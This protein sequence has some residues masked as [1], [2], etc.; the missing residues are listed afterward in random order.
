MKTTPAIF[1][2]GPTASGKTDL[3]IKLRDHF[4]LDIISVDSAQVFREMNIGTAKPDTDELEK[5]PHKLIDIKDPDESYSAADFRIDAL[6]EMKSIRDQKRI[7]L[8]VGGTNLYFRALQYGLSDLP[9]SDPE[10]RKQ[11]EMRIQSEGLKALHDELKNVDAIA[12]GRIHQND[13]QRTMRALEVYLLTGTPM[14]ALQGQAQADDFCFSVFKIQ[15]SPADRSG[16][17]QRIAIRFR[18]MI[19]NGLIE[20]VKV[21]RQRWPLHADLP[22]MRAVGYRQVWDYLEG[23]RD[24]EE[25]IEKGIIATRQLAK[26]QLTWL[27]QEQAIL[28]VNESDAETLSE[29]VEKIRE[30]L[31]MSFS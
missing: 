24:R 26:R 16:L 12:A 11:L 6:R 14:S 28:R 9:P 2:M 13:Q 30:F 3:A 27:R 15:I 19:D 20:E 22:S 8:L 4:P 5:A 7:P 18:Q 31:Q 17:H 23:K 21:L 10:I 29:I 25:M 1:I